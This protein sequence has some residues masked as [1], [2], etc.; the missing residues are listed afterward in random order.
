M[1][2][3]HRDKKAQDQYMAALS[4]WRE[5]KDSTAQ[6]LVLAQSY[7]GD[8]TSEILLQPGE[9][10]F[11]KVSGA[12]LIEDRRGAGHYE[13]RSSGFSVPVVSLGGHQVRYRV[14]VSSGNF[15]QGAPVSTSIDTGTLF[16]TDKRVI[17]QGGKQT[18]EC[19]FAKLVGF[20]HSPDGAT[21]FSV[22]NRQKPT[23]VHYGPELAGW[24]DFR[25]DLALAHY[26]GTVS[27]LVAGL[28][29]QLAQ[30]EQAQPVAPSP[31]A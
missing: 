1:F 23:T 8:R 6:L 31:T 12:S 28:E 16:V 27:E 14:G 10:Q 13:G 18:R 29:A 19:L 24:F 5:L 9:A 3:A 15:V 20:V 21:T 22:S 25:L 11:A 4:H 2:E 26:K 30:V 7:K 17:F